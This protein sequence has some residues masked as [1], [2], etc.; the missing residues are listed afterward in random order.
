MP[1]PA[2]KGPSLT[3]FQI[4]LSGEN[5][6]GQAQSRSLP[7]LVGLQTPPSTSKAKDQEGCNPKSSACGGGWAVVLSLRLEIQMWGWSS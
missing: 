7:L 3:L 2:K 6:R 4:Q 1:L 5:L